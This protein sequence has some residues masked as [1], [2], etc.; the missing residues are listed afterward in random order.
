M[1][2]DN[3]LLRHYPG[4]K[5]L[6]VHVDAGRSGRHVR[7][8]TGASD[9]RRELAD[10][11]GAAIIATAGVAPLRH[12]DGWAWPRCS[13]TDLVEALRSELPG[14]RLLGATTPR[15]PGRQRLSLLG[16]AAGTLT[17]IKLGT[18]S[19]PAPNE[20]S[21]N[22][23]STNSAGTEESS[24]GSLATEAAVLQM[25]ET[26][27]LPGI[28]TPV[29]LAAGTISCRTN[30]ST[31]TPSTATDAPADIE[32]VAT[33]SI[34]IGSQRA[35][36]DAPLRTFTADLGTRLADLPRPSGASRDAVPIHGDLTPW[37][38]RRTRRGLA[39]F[40]W[41]S[42]GWGPASFDLDT[43]RRACDEVRPA[44]PF[45]TRQPPR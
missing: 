12:A 14:F 18:G 45:R 7:S 3:T 20:S 40:D 15:Q 24:T 6:L 28:A 29:V 13:V 38:L 17:V 9:W 2:D 41:E 19:H 43:Y 39:L 34:A 35:A 31:T 44:L 25:L 36:V 8:L 11:T 10:R 1:D 27:P 26:H 42:A 5:R 37:N 32:F 16:R 21:T 22:E 30:P 33:T 23:S 4:A